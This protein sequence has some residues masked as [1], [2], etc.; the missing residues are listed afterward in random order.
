M[1][2]DTSASS[3]ALP[4]RPNLRFLKLEAK[5]RL[6][7]GEFPTLH[8]AQLAVAREH[9]MPSWT[10]LKEHIAALDTAGV[11]ADADVDAGVDHQALAQVRWV[12]DRFRGADR[13]GWTAPDRAELGEHFA[14]HFL[15]MVPP[16]QIAATLAG[17][18]ARLREPLTVLGSAPQALRAGLG[19][20][21]VEAVAD[22]LP[23]HRLVGL[24]V[25]PAGL[26]VRD[27]RVTEPP[28]SSDGPVPEEAA[29]LV[30]ESL[31]DVGLVGLVAAGPSWSQARGWADLEQDV[32]LRPDHR[33][34]AYAITKLITA[35]AVLHLV[36]EGALALDDRVDDHLRTLRLADSKVTVR[37][38]LSHTGGVDNPEQAFG[39]PVTDVGALLGPVVGCSGPRGEFAYSHG[40]FAVLG[41]LVAQLTGLPYAEAAARLV[42][43]PLGMDASSYPLAVPEADAVT[44]YRLG[45]DGQFEPVA[46]PLATLQAAAGLWST[47]PDLVRFAAGWRS[48]LPDE[49]AEQALTPQAPRD[50]SGAAIGLGWLLHLTRDAVGHGG[51][52]D[53]SATSLLVRPSTGQVGVVHANRQIPAEPLNAKLLRITA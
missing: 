20:L 25:Y 52:G 16:E 32:P 8:D 10:A 23:P 2:S 7:A 34:P 46:T 31:A 6:A 26:R 9:G 39:E 30:A 18:A 1:S 17:Q 42:L 35:T 40:G 19:D 50:D 36:G 41:E 43:R 49:L 45:Q 21:R 37:Q 33:F 53:A 24:R 51:G 13:P 14:D 47:A 44:G 12:V 38:L 4:D 15:S 22:R 5:R 3:R 28:T 11:D 29:E 27:P 48:L